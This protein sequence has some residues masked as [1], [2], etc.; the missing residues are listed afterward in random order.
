MHTDKRCRRIK[1]QRAPRNQVKSLNGTARP[2][3]IANRP[4]FLKTSPSHM[5]LLKETRRTFISSALQLLG[6]DACMITNYCE[7]NYISSGSTSCLPI[8]A[9]L[10]GRRW[11][12]EDDYRARTQSRVHIRLYS[13]IKAWYVAVPKI[14]QVRGQRS[15]G[16][17]C[18]SNEAEPMSWVLRLDR[19]TNTSVF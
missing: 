4:L 10:R 14:V 13:Q 1:P 15:H 5:P 12:R 18:T 16:C 3:L 11:A 9:W 6:L 2:M 7:N 17:S 8:H 19:K